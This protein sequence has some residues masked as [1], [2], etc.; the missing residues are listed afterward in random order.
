MRLPRQS[1]ASLLHE[2]ERV[3]GPEGM[4]VLALERLKVGRA[5]LAVT[6]GGDDLA[7]AF[8]VKCGQEFAPIRARQYEALEAGSWA[9][10]FEG[11]GDC[12]AACGALGMGCAKQGS[13]G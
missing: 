3:D 1:I 8:G 5:V 9:V 12:T 6:R 4:L 7:E 10:E 11:K 13:I 2:P